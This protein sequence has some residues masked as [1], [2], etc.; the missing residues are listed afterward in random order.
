MGNSSVRS[1]MSTG[2]SGGSVSGEE[3]TTRMGVDE[4]RPPVESYADLEGRGR[5]GEMGVG[6]G[7]DEGMRMDEDEDEVDDG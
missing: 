5:A 7:R 1:R 2:G 3:R 4:D 6:V